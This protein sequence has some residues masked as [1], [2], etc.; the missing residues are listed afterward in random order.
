MGKTMADVLRGEGAIEGARKTKQE[1][2]LR[3]LRKKF[4]L[5][6]VPAAIEAE[7]RATSDDGK[8]DQ[9]LDELV[10]KGELADMSF[11]SGS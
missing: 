2:I 11:T 8:L 10:T 7:V 3:Q 6:K 5:T 1:T 4:H 9:W